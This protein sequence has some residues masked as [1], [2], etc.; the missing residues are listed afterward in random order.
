MESTFDITDLWE[1]MRQTYPIAM[2]KWLG[3][4]DNEEKAKYQITKTLHD[5]P[6]W[7][8]RSSNFLLRLISYDE[9]GYRTK[10]DE[11]KPR[12]R[13]ALAFVQR[14]AQNSDFYAFLK[15]TFDVHGRDTEDEQANIAPENAAVPTDQPADSEP[16]EKTPLNEPNE[17]KDA[18]PKKR[19][20]GIIHELAES[21]LCV[22][23]KKFLTESNVNARNNIGETALHLAA[24]FE[25]PDDVEVLLKN[26]ATFKVCVTN[27]SPGPGTVHVL[28]FVK[29]TPLVSKYSPGFSG[30]CLL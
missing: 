8:D 2:N 30:H 25:N 20:N 27:V 18:S 28:I 4:F 13:L 17:T 1:E 12:V 3:C 26:G 21:G 14:M 6:K 16:S 19:R 23:L 11:P 5:Q 15:A 22:A 10:E 7:K 24:E 29:L 9:N